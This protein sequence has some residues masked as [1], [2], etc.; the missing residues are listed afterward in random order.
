M[1][2]VVI[3][4]GGAA[5]V[6][7]AIF[8]AHGGSEVLVLEKGPRPLTKVAI[9]GGG[10][11]NV[12]HDCRDPHEMT[13]F[14]PRGGRELLGPFTRFGVDDTVDFFLA[15][16]VNLK[17]ESDGRMFPV[18]DE[19]DTVTGALLA[20]CLLAQVDIRP[21]VTV[22]TARREGT[23]FLVTLSTG[24]VVA[25]DRLLI[26]SGGMRSREGARL[27]AR[28]GHSIIEPVPSLFTFHVDDSRLRDLAGVSVPDARV[29]VVGVRGLVQR[30][31]LLITHWGLSGPAV[32]KLS[33]W[34]ALDLWSRDYKFEILVDW[35]PAAGSEGLAEAVAVA[36]KENPRRQ[37][38][39]GPLLDLP[40]RLWERLVVA[41]G[42]DR[43]RIYAELSRAEMQA[44]SDQLRESRLR[45][46]GKSLNK[47]EFVTCGGVALGEVDF[48][49]MESRLV[50]GLYF[51]GEVLDIDGVT[52]G[53][54]LQAAWTTGYL[55][56]RAMSGAVEEDL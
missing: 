8:A 51:A 55:A 18:T 34:G 41:A 45:V 5:G 43:G 38:A 2:R 31:P 47:D 10:R 32:L 3:V 23:E 26:A 12:T 46:D 44:L 50:P 27:P 37:V 20:A 40:K 52:G 19:S 54:N 30:G 42:V 53:F 13:R 49:T 33:A 24:D 4:G 17:T 56:G 6:F 29:E 21:R 14:Y 36:R 39:R 15:Q 1:G 16:G 22:Q 11:C 28:F 25:C 9:S 35:I 48:R 7:A